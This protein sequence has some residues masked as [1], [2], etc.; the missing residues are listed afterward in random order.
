MC[1]TLIFIAN[2]LQHLKMISNYLV[3]GYKYINYVYFLSNTHVNLGQFIT[4]SLFR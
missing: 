4:F 2:Y 1:S 3:T